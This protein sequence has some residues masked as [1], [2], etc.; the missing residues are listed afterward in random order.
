MKQVRRGQNVMPNSRYLTRKS[1]TANVTAKHY[2][3]SSILP[4]NNTYL[5]EFYRETSADLP[6]FYR[7]PFRPFWILTQNITRL[8]IYLLYY[9]ALFPSFTQHLAKWWIFPI[10]GWYKQTFPSSSL[11]KFRIDTRHCRC[12]I[13][14]TCLTLT[15]VLCK[16]T[17]YFFIMP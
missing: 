2:R 13:Y 14:F 7:K 4:Q 1:L 11:L 9:I 17:F 5:S 3:P 6:D 8:V 15:Y 12:V 16:S 10:P